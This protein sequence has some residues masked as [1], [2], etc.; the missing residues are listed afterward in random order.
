MYTKHFAQFWCAMCGGASPLSLQQFYPPFIC[1][2]LSVVKLSLNQRQD[3][4]DGTSGI[5]L[6]YHV[7]SHHFTPDINPRGCPPSFMNHPLQ[8]LVGCQAIQVAIPKRQDSEVERCENG[9]VLWFGWYPMA[10]S[11]S[12]RGGRLFWDPKCG[13]T[14]VGFHVTTHN[15]AYC[16]RFG[17]ALR[18]I[19]HCNWERLE[20]ES[21]LH[22]YILANVKVALLLATKFECNNHTVVSIVSGALICYCEPYLGKMPVLTDSLKLQPTRGCLLWQ[23]SLC[24]SYCIPFFF[25]ER[26]GAFD[27]YRLYMSKSWYTV[28]YSS[29][30]SMMWMSNANTTF[31]PLWFSNICRLSPEDFLIIS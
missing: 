26:R 14:W 18:K 30:L 25:W 23:F 15:D 4:S 27:E 1:A 20:N 5:P 9:G 24:S 29:N 31:P 6:Y 12:H 3:K 10:S 13:R 17:Y 7:L 16:R 2:F 21:F 22:V 28:C 8:T 11:S 19:T